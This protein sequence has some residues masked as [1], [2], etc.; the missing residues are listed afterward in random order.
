MV[1]VYLTANDLHNLVKVKLQDEKTDF[2]KKLLY[3]MTKQNCPSNRILLCPKLPLL[4]LI[5]LKEQF[6]S[7]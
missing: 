3:D 2:K 6:L 1:K 4:L 5:N 7:R